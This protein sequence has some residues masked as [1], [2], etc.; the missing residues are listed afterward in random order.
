M[1]DCRCSIGSEGDGEYPEFSD[2]RHVKA[3]KTH[4]CCECGK[5]IQRGETYQ[6]WVG[7]FDGEMG[8]EKTCLICAEIRSSFSCEAWPLFGYMWAEIKDHMFPELTTAC[9][10]RLSTPEARSIV[11]RRWREWKGLAA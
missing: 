5:D 10:D 11:Q 9:Y 6:Y 2:V 1:S 4:Q 7:K 8:Y 3:R